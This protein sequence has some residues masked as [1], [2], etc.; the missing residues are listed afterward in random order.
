MENVDYAA[1]QK[2]KFGSTKYNF[3]N[4]LNIYVNGELYTATALTPATAGVDATI[5]TILDAAT[6]NV[7]FA[8]V[9]P[10]AT[11][12]DTIFVDAY[13]MGQ[14]TNVSYKNEVTTVKFSPASNNLG[15]YKKIE[16]ADNDID[17]DAVKV[18]VTLDGE[19]IALKDIQENDIIAVKTKIG[20]TTD[21][22]ASNENITI[23]VSRDTISGRV[24]SIEDG[25]GE[26]AYVIDGTTYAAVDKTNVGLSVGEIYN[27]IYLDSFGRVYSYD[28]EAVEDTTKYAILAKVTDKTD[29]ILVLPDGTR[30]SYE[31]KS[32]DIFGTGEGDMTAL[33]VNNGPIAT[34]DT[35]GDST[36]EPVVVPGTVLNA[37]VKYTVKNGQINS[38]APETGVAFTGAYKDS[39]AKVQTVGIGEGSGVVIADTASYKD[40]K[41]MKA[42]DFVDGEVYT[43]A[44]FG[45]IGSTSNYSLVVVTVAGFDFGANSRFAVVNAGSF[46]S[47]IDAD[48][49]SVDQLKVL[50]NGEKTTLDFAPSAKSAFG[51]V[52]Y[53]DAFFYTVDSDGLVNVTKKITKANITGTMPTLAALFG[54]AYDST[55]WGTTLS[56]SD[57]I[58][59]VTGL[60]VK[61]GTNSVSL[62]AKPAAA[63]APVD[64]DA[65][66]TF[67][68]ADDCVIYTYDTDTEVADKNKLDEEGVLVAMSYK[69]WTITENP[70]ATPAEAY[71][72]AN[73]N[74]VYDLGETFTDANGNGVWDAAVPVPAGYSTAS[75][76]QIAWGFTPTKVEALK[77]RGI[78]TS[79][80]DTLDGTTAA[81]NAQ[82]ALALIVDDKVV[83]IYEILAD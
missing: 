27:K 4:S 79:K 32:A 21:I 44:G 80:F 20:T 37:V 77:A 39:V 48:G 15:S 67:S 16:I 45:K 7:K 63:D 56:G 52:N 34:V 5:Q 2:I 69:D 58:M 74:G 22:T 31:A 66:E 46:S 83:E 14:V 65:F 6:G 53:G 49:D 59:L 24:T 17:T 81:D 3:A 47:G 60:V 29:I 55:K 78:K 73:S 42:S 18:S 61:A 36:L 9:A 70:T 25:T 50:V 51:A 54:A 26:N 10:G 38:I 1:N 33:E 64:F 8:K 41:A 71:T 13:I 28:D 11:N 43:G 30:K 62:L 75:I 19:A 35:D 12:Y 76:G 23:L 57:D 40:Y 68:L 82:Y 72:D